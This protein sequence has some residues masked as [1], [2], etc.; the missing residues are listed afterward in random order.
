MSTDTM[1]GEETAQKER[2]TGME[3]SKNTGREKKKK[4]CTR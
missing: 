3:N 1:K 4:I 2:T